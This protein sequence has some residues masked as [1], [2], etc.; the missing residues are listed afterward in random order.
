MITVGKLADDSMHG[1]W[2]PA[3]NS[4]C[5]VVRD[6]NNNYI[7]SMPIALGLLAEYDYPFEEIEWCKACYDDDDNMIPCD[8]VDDSR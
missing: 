1:L 5:N 6:C 4:W 8:Q 3:T 2:V 7:V